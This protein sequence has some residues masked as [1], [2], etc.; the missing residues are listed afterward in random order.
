MLPAR[1]PKKPKRSTRWRSQAHTAYVR[2]FCCAM[3]GSST[4]VIAAHVR[5]NSGAGGAQKPDDWLTV[6]LCDGP[7]SNIDN[8]LGCHQV[9]H[10]IGE[11]TFW[12]SYKQKHGQS[13]WQLLA[14]I[15]GTSPKRFEIVKV[16]K[17]RDNG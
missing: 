5:I 15:R 9:Q 6:P 14:E 7:F 4:N 10:S 17:E 11:G 3:C 13:V 12:T 16:M 8:Q 1:I 2:S